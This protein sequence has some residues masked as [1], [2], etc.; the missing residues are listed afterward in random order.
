MQNLCLTYLPDEGLRSEVED[1][2][3]A[4]GA[5]TPLNIDPQAWNPTGPTARAAQLAVLELSPATATAYP[6]LCEALRT[7][8]RI[9]FLTLLDF[10]D[11]NMVLLARSSG[12]AALIDRNQAAIL[13]FLTRKSTTNPPTKSDLPPDQIP[14][15]HRLTVLNG[16]IF[17]RKSN[18]LIKVR[19]EDLCYIKGMGNYA[20]LHTKNE[21]LVVTYT[22]KNL[23]DI[24]PRHLFSRVHRSYIVNLDHIESITPSGIM[25]NGQEIPISKS[26]RKFILNSIHVV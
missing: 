21:R 25:L 26:Y 16:G 4:A 22:L 15:K 12:A 7:Q 11:A 10:S 23:Q 20:T 24:L 9:P 6:Q 5:P 2:L 13:P 8:T 19:V 17:V 18:R 3:R 14:G 1:Q